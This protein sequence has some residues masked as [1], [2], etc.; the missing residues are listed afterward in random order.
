MAYDFLNAYRS[1]D[2]ELNFRAEDLK[3][4]LYH[5]DNQAYVCRIK[6]RYYRCELNQKETIENRLL[7]D[8]AKIRDFL[9]DYGFSADIQVED[10]CRPMI[11]YLQICSL[12]LKFRIDLKRSI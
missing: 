2:Q 3:R 7:D 12:A 5:T 4:H 6:S 8:K 9:I 11:A 1:G 10:I